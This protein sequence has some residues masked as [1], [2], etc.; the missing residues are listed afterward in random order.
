MQRTNIYL[1]EEQTRRLDELARAQHTSRAE[2]IRRI[3]DRSFAG[4][5]ESAQRREVIDF[6][7]GALSGFEIEWADREDGDRAAY[8]GGLW[9]DPLT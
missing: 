1:D 2:I 5:G 6:T 9:Q 7:F 8:L 3:I 4:D